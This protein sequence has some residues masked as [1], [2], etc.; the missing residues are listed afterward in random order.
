MKVWEKKQLCRLK[1]VEKSPGFEPITIFMQSVNYQ[2]T[3][4]C[5]NG[6]CGIAVV[7][8]FQTIRSTKLASQ[9]WIITV[10]AV[11]ESGESRKQYYNIQIK[12]ICLSK[13]ISHSPTATSKC[14]TQLTES[15]I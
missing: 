13:T 9:Y 15:R 11:L 2:Y 1:S 5:R 14:C 6:V 7:K 8:I 12:L 4:T 10:I 3:V